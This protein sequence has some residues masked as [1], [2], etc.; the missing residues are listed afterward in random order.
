MR[1]SLLARHA[2]LTTNMLTKNKKLSEENESMPT[3]H[4]AKHAANDRIRNHDKNGAKLGK[5]SEKNHDQSSILNHTPTA[6][7]NDDQ[8]IQRK[9]SKQINERENHR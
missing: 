2:R 5:C 3:K 1:V 9:T 6:N 8:R 4:D 7:L